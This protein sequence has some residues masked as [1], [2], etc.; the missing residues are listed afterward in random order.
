MEH[1]DQLCRAEKGRAS[2]SSSFWI[3]CNFEKL[4]SAA[5]LYLFSGLSM[6]LESQIL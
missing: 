5:N 4:E 1:S 2:I 6:T 3:I